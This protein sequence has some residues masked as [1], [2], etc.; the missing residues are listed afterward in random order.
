MS[1]W[2]KRSWVGTPATV[3]QVQ[4]ATKLSAGSC[5]NALRTL[6]DLGLLHFHS[7]ATRGRGSARHIVDVDALLDA[8]ARTAPT[9]APPEQITIGVTWRDTINGV[10]ELGPIFSDLGISWAATEVV[11]AAL[12]HRCSPTSQPPSSVDV[13]TAG[14]RGE[15]ATGHLRELSHAG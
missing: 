12:L 6:T 1:P 11:A 15:D 9:M 14:V 3:A 13:R 7:E 4:S 8:Y 10:R 5:T 2:P